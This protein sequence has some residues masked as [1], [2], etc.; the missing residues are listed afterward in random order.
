MFGPSADVSKRSWVLN[1]TFGLHANAAIVAVAGKVLQ[2]GSSP[3]R[4]FFAGDG[5]GAGFD[6]CI[7]HSSASFS[8]TTFSEA[9]IAAAVKAQWMVARFQEATKSTVTRMRRIAARPGIRSG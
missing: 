3:Q 9:A 6:A 4:L 1:E 5:C 2:H 7:G 8:K